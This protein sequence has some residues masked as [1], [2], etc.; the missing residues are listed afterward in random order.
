LLSNYRPI[1]L[2]PFL[3]KVLEK[4]V[5]K[6]L[7][8]H[9]EKH[10]LLTRFQSD[11]RR[12][13]STEIAVVRIANIILSSNDSGTVT[14]LVLLDLSAACDTIDHEILLSRL[15]TDIGVTRTALSWFR[16]YLA[17]RSRL[18]PVRGTLY[19]LVLSHDASHRDQF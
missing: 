4:V 12:C 11:F 3:S 8:V 17:G 18:F 19:R 6:Q 7:T 9:L 13:H 2:L 16:F 5:A 14:A 1:Y 15:E 10:N